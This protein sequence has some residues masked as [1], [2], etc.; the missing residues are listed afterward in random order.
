MLTKLLLGNKMKGYQD[1]Q[2]F[3]Q[4]WFWEDLSQHGRQAQA[5]KGKL[6][7]YGK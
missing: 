7:K 6:K 2:P 1:C 4:Q 3:L 5:G